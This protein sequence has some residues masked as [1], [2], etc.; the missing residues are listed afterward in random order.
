MRSRY[1]AYVKRNVPYL[2]DTWHP[3]TRPMHLL[4]NTS[5]APRWTGLKILR[6][7]AGLADDSTGTVE[8]EARYKLN[9]RACRLHE[10]SR[11][12]QLDGRWYYLDGNV[13]Q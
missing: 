9:G 13:D 5:G 8:F 10:V 7:A 1:T 2:Q 3:E 12:V 4:L 6:T 11:F